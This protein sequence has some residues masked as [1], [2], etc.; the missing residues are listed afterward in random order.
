MRKMLVEETTYGD[1]SCCTPS[2]LM[3]V[4][5]GPLA[6]QQFL[7]RVRDSIS[8]Q[9]LYMKTKRRDSKKKGLDS[10][11]NPLRQN[12]SPGMFHSKLSEYCGSNA[13]LES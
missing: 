2:K 9:N 1:P 8:T 7:M 10:A 3:A 12:R 5:L 13:A 11:K 4:S 6:V